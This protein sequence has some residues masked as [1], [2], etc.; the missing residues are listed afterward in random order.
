MIARNSITP[1]CRTYGFFTNDGK[2]KSARAATK[3][4]RIGR[5]D[6]PRGCI[7]GRAVMGARGSGARLA[8]QA[9][10]PEEEEPEEQDEHHELLEARGDVHGGQGLRHADDDAAERG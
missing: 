3:K 7:R 4:R 2:T 8:E 9:G 6:T 10:G 1:M 5:T